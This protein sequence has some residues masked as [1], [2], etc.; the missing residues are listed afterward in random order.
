MKDEFFRG[1]HNRSSRFF[2]AAQE[3]AGFPF[4]LLSPPQ[5][6]WT[7]PC[8]SVSIVIP[9]LNEEKNIDRCIRSVSGNRH[10]LEVIVVDGGS[11]DNTRLVASRSGARVVVHNRPPEDGGGR[12]GQIKR[13]IM[14]AGGDAVV[15][16]HADALL[17]DKNVDRIITLLNRYPD[18]VGGSVGCR[19]ES[20]AFRLRIIELANDIRAAFLKISFGDQV[21]FF[22]RRPVVARDLFPDIP[23]MEDV[24]FSIRLHRLGRQL[25]LFGNARVSSR[26][27]EKIG[28][29]NAPWVFIT[30]LIYIIR[31]IFATPDTAVLYEKYYNSNKF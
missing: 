11:G 8:R 17:P 24:E 20:S 28:F 18:V 30:V 13:G 14:A 1:L 27:W 2:I 19:F 22:R 7:T 21:Q 5:D 29:R 25:H 15:I 12:G 16:L 3:A 9:T 31:R 10:V 23:L 6:R 4:R 26:R